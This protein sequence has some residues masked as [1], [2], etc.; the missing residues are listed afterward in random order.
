M[1]SGYSEIKN[2]NQE[3]N[4]AVLLAVA[5]SMEVILCGLTGDFYC[6]ATGNGGVLNH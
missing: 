2:Q 6:A 5:L 4:I 3:L 1:S